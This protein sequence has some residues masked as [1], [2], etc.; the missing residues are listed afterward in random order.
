M[1]TKKCTPILFVAS[2]EDSLPFWVERLGFE[3]TMS[4]PE[5]DQLGF[6]GLQCGPVEVM[7]QT[8]ASLEKD[9]PALA[10]EENRGPSFLFIEVEDLAAVETQL[11]PSEVLV[12]RRETFYGSKE[13]V[14]REPGGHVVTF[15]Q[16]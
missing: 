2:I 9:L 3:Q 7:L 4:V 14:A 11:E 16:F 1:Q 10:T 13:V 15:A 5:G 6:V 12:P 8:F